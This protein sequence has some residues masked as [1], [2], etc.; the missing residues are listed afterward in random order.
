MPNSIFNGLA[1]GF[2]AGAGVGMDETGV[3]AG[4]E[5]ALFAAVDPFATPLDTLD[6]SLGDEYADAGI[7]GW[8]DTGA[9]LFLLSNRPGGGTF[10]RGEF[11]SFKRLS[12]SSK[13]ASSLL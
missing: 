2:G 5:L 7:C 11:N 9:A 4:A 6:V 3:G 8:N 12:C 10:G 13:T 1:A